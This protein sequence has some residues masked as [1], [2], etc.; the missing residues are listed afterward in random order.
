MQI[1]V[2]GGCILVGFVDME[3]ELG[4]KYLQNRHKSKFYQEV[5]FFL[6]QE[7]LGRLKPAGLGTTE[8][9]QTLISDDTDQAVIDGFGRGAFVVIK[10]IKEM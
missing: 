9:R 6:T 3:S 5:T 10:A 4:Q 1:L 8:V 2:A 7:V